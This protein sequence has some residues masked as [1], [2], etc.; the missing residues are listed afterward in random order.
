M[1]ARPF[2]TSVVA[3]AVIVAL[4]SRAHA[5][6]ET[7]APVHARPDIGILGGV[8]FAK[9]EGN[10][11]FRTPDARKAFVGGG[12][13]LFHLHH[14]LGIEPEL[15]YAQQGGRND[16]TDAEL[17]L[18]YVQLPVLLRYDF[19][20]PST[21]HPFVYGGP[22]FSLEVNCSRTTEGHAVDCD[23]SSIHQRPFDFAGVIGAGVSLK[24]GREAV[25]LSARYLAGTAEV[26]D[27]GVGKNRVLSFVAGVSF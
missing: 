4:P 6:A 7:A 15:L 8:N 27:N 5:Q 20:E 23:Q 11:F 26:F 22:A 16:D 13:V 14:G 18:D 3:L 12:F 17:R 9:V 10:D 1:H 2:V 21:V 25:S 19:L 24:V